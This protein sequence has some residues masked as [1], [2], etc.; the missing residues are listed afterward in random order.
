[1]EAVGYDL[2]FVDDGKANLLPF[3]PALV[4]KDKMTADAF[5]KSANKHY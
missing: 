4:D 5:G 1:M 3:D 2:I